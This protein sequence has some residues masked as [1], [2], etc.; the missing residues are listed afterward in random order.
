MTCA[1]GPSPLPRSSARAMTAGRSPSS[2]MAAWFER[3]SR[4]H[5]ASRPRRSSGSTSGTPACRVVDWFDG[6][7]PV[8]RLVNGAAADLPALRLG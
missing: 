8:V 2:R 1:T 5:S 3:S 7:A 4:M 6:D